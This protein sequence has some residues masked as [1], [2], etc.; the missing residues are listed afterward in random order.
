MIGGNCGGIRAQIDDGHT[1]FLVDS[2]S[3]CARR[4]VEL[5]RDPDMARRMG[6]A[7]RESVRERYLTSR[8]LA[9]YLSLVRELAGSQ[10]S[11]SS[12]IRTLTHPTSAAADS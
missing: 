2:P 3:E 1:G 4:A 8:V 6:I 10:A 12:L 5:L 7:A 11:S 9:D